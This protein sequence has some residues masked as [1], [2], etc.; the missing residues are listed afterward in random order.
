MRSFV[1]SANPART[2]FGPGAIGELRTEIERLGKRRVMII[3]GPELADAAA[4]AQEV[5]GSLVVAGFDGVAMH[6]PVE[7]TERA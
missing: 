6:T 7:V 1:Y 3:A 2:I 4:R 5:L